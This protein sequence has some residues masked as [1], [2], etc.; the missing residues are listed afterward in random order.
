M[1]L[2]NLTKDEINEIIAELKAQGYDVRENRKSV[3]LEQ[4]AEKLGMVDCYFANEL[5]KS[6][7][8]IADFATDNTEKKTPAYEGATTRRH[9]KGTVD[10]SIDKDYRE[11]CSG[12]LKTI[13]PYYGRQGFRSRSM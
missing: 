2:E 9:K 12:I 13:Q 7:L 10:A 8:N 5:R 3:I 6:I 1:K 11:I 4:E